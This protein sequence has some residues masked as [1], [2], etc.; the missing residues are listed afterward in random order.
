MIAPGCKNDTVPHLSQDAPTEEF[1]SAEACYED[2]IGGASNEL[3]RFHSSKDSRSSVEKYKSISSLLESKS[4]DITNCLSFSKYTNR[5]AQDSESF[6]KAILIVATARA[7]VYN[8]KIAEKPWED[9]DIVL[10]QQGLSG[11]EIDYDLSKL[12][13]SNCWEDC[14]P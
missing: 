7:Y 14:D 12:P 3:D 9:S 1:D 5:T 6:N 4:T 11:E 13:G 10:I 8:F 2:A